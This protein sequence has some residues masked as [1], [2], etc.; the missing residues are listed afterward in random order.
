MKIIAGERKGHS[1][2]TPS[3]TETRPT[4]TRVRESLFSIIAGDLPGSTFYDLFAGAGIIGL[5]ALSRGAERAVFVESAKK[6]YQSLQTNIERLRY[7]DRAR[8]VMSDAMS[9]PIPG[10]LSNSQ[11]IFADPPYQPEVIEKFLRRLES[12]KIDPDT[13]IILQTPAR[14]K[15]ES[16]VLRHLRTAKYGNTALHFYLV[17]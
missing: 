1:L 16:E 6:P 7:Q 13:L 17:R 5:E 2:D 11:I 8:A 4:L 12:S 3:G 9:W 10:D 14:F 15:A